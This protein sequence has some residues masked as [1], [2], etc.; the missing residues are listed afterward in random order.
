MRG[1]WERVRSE[2]DLEAEAGFRISL[3]AHHKNVTFAPPTREGM[4]RS[5]PEPRSAPVA[6]KQRLV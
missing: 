3:E 5:S 2:P 6:F 4:N 1:L